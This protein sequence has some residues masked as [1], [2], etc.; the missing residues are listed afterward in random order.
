MATLRVSARHL[1]LDLRLIE[2]IGALRIAP[3]VPLDAIRS[4]EVVD[5]PWSV[6]RGLRVGTGLPGVVLLGTMLRRGGN[7]L[8]AIRGRGP[9][10][11]VHLE[12]HTG[13]QRWICTSA[14]ADALRDRIEKARVG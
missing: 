4:V 13:W 10:V 12:A 6:V 5:A 14:E 9:A 7:D 3:R 1:H 11:V 2:R 8:V